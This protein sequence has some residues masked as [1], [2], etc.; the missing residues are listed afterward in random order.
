VGP[1]GKQ[2]SLAAIFTAIV[3]D[4]SKPK[5]IPNGAS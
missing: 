2:N 3:D 1:D 4:L 5:L